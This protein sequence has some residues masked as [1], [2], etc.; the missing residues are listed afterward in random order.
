MAANVVIN[1]RHGVNVD[2]VPTVLIAGLLSL[3]IALTLAL[4]NTGQAVTLDLGESA[5][6]H[7]RNKRPA[8]ER[9]ARIAHR[10]ELGPRVLEDDPA[11]RCGDAPTDTMLAVR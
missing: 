11:A 6:I 4:P 7:P 5:D 1:R 9:L 2:M 3:P 10:G 8:G